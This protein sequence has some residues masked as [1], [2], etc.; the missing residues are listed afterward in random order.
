MSMLSNILIISDFSK[1]RELGKKYKMNHS[2]VVP[3]KRKKSKPMQE[4]SKTKQEL[5]KE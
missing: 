3:F 1:E 5:R 2:K 4:E